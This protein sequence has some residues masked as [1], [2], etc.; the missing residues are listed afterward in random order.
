MINT[1]QNAFAWAKGPCKVCAQLFPSSLDGVVLEETCRT[2]QTL[3]CSSSMLAWTPSELK[4]TTPGDGNGKLAYCL[5]MLPAQLAHTKCCWA[6]ESALEDVYMN[7][8]LRRDRQMVHESKNRA[9]R[10]AQPGFPSRIPNHDGKGRT[11]PE[12]TE[13]LQKRH[14]IIQNFRDVKHQ[15]LRAQS[16]PDLCTISISVVGGAR[17][18]TRSSS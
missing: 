13:L 11:L 6:A 12:M 16:S 8:A 14:P 5:T 10:P 4:G 1:A 17:H 9:P 7:V 2:S 18:R 15:R 3:Q